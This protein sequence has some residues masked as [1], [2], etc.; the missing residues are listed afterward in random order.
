MSEKRYVKWSAKKFDWQYWEFFVLSI[1]KEDFNSLP[2]TKWY[3]RILMSEKKNT[4]EYWN[5][6]S[7]VLSEDKPKK[8]IPEMPF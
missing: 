3:V 2:D 8:E 1:Q 4:D 7:L 5:T 6:H